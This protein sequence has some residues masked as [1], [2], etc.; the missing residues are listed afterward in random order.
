ME[1]LSPA[2]SPEG[3]AAS[4]K[5]GCDAVYLGGKSFGA[6]A[7]ADNFS[8]GQ[9]EGAVRYAHEHGVKVNVTVNT[10][11][12]DSE[13][14]DAVAFVEFLRRIRADAVIIQDLGLLENIRDIKIQKHASTQMGI[15][16]RKGLEWCAENGLDR[17][18]LARELTME[19][20][21]RIVG[22]SPVETEVFV[23]GAMCYCVSGGCLMSSLIGGRS[24]NRGECAQP[25]RKRYSFDGREGY[26]L[27]SA[28]L[29]GIGYLDALSEIGVT[30]V[31][32]EGR[33]RSP[34]Y[35]YLAT[36]SYVMARDHAPEEERR[37]TDEL[38]RTVFNR[39]TCEGY[40]GGVVSPV[41]AK[42]PDN[43]GHFICRA[44]VKD[45]RFDISGTDLNPGDGVSLFSGDAKVGGF[46]V[47]EG[48]TAVS[49]FRMPDGEYD[50]YRTYDPRIDTVKN[51][52]GRA[53]AL[54]GKTP[55]P[56][57]RLEKEKMPRAK[58]RAD[59]SFYVSSLRNLEIVLPAADR[60]Y[61][62]YGSRL[63]EA[64]EMCDAA[65]VECVTCLPRFTPDD[66]SPEDGRPVMVHSPGQFAANR[67]RRVY[68]SHFTNMFN[69]HYPGMFHQTALSVELSKREIGEVLSHREGRAE[70]MVFGRLEMAFSRDPGSGSGILKDEKGYEFPIYRDELGYTRILNSADLMLLEHLG[71]L[72]H[73]G[74]DSF[75]I[76]VR[77]RPPAL[78][79][80]VAEAFRRR[81]LSK[82][83]KITGMCSAV[84]YGHYARGV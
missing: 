69:S 43:R 18:I 2:G 53:P 79:K 48:S 8:D 44:A 41:Q 52:I 73:M 19:E 76:D 55:R 5:A 63:G 62:E 20:L 38:L 49:P 31:K 36:R 80:E 82:K 56:P 13:M 9:L 6:R 14:E 66:L 24:G 28:D 77:K 78:V 74:A 4:V 39:G 1:I 83:V 72:E 75:G 12:K 46:K 3:L 59:L 29:Y 81:D 26:L 10:L 47:G 50:V 64:G 16:S 23:Q 42:Y 57:V 61:F 7:F 32:I 65:G 22:E 68:G 54:N 37:E 71:D 60:V 35:A 11:I 84:T 58:S 25:C 30:S 33:M 21:R 70:V 51:L 27:S 17:A 40:L 45:R 15:H 34:A 67:H